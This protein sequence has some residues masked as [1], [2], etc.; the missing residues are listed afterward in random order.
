MDNPR[1]DK[2]YTVVVDD[3][4]ATSPDAGLNLKHRFEESNIHFTCDKDT[5]VGA[6]LIH[7]KGPVM[8]KSDGR[9]K[10]VD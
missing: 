10:A 1:K 5:F 6:Y 8:I 7:N 9:I 2:F 4:C 3:Y